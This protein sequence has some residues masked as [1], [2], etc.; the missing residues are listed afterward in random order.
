VFVETGVQARF[1]F[2]FVS[3]SSGLKPV[4]LSS[5]TGRDL[6]CV[7]AKS[8]HSKDGVRAQPVE[9]NACWMVWRE[10]SRDVIFKLLTR[11]NSKW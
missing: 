3:R 10:V 7:L 8:T 5:F 2:V 9:R 1:I 4:L 11:F 6:G